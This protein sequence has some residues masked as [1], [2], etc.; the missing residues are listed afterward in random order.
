M[1]PDWLD[2]TKRVLRDL[3]QLRR[4]LRPTFHLPD[5][6]AVDAGFLRHH[7]IRGVVWDVDGTL[8]SYHARAIAPEFREHMRMLFSDDA[9]PHAVVSNCD[10]ARFVELTRMLP[11]AA[12]VRLYDTPEGPVTRW[13]R[14]GVDS[15]EPTGPPAAPAI[16]KPSA[17]LIRASA[18]VLGGVAVDQLLVVGDQYFT[19]VA[20]A[21][22]AGARSAKVATYRRE[23]F[24]LIVQLAQ[25][26]EALLAGGRSATRAAPPG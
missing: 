26:L 14:G 4:H 23:T 8:M 24:P 22:L 18:E 7:D 21:S 11:E 5:V 15:L 12:L 1:R 25:R 2:T 17:A 3:P 19:D 9:L 16:R 20:S 13:V 6:R 10:E